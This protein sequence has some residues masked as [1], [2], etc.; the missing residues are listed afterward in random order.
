VKKDVTTKDVNY[1]HE[2]EEGE[3]KSE[4]SL[5]ELL[6]HKINCVC[7]HR[8]TAGKCALFL[9]KLQLIIEKSILKNKILI[10]AEKGTQM[11]PIQLQI[12]G[13]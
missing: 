9:N 2:L 11:S 12:K 8:T 1:L 10:T 4:S 13:S 6:H 3:K 7:I 5:N